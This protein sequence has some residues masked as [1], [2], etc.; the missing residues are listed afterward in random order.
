MLDPG[1]LMMSKK[2][3][4]SLPH[5]AYNLVGETENDQI[6]TLVNGKVS[7]DGKC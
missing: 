7:I 2:R 6:I 4:Q 3:L 1:D 5:E